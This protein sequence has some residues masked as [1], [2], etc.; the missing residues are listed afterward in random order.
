MNDH[1]IHQNRIRQVF[2]IML[3]AL[4]GLLL[5]LELYVFLPALLGAITLYIIMREW[6][7]HLTLKKKWRKSLTAAMLMF[8]ALIIILLPIGVLINMLSAKVTFAIQHSNELITALKTIV[9]DIEKKYD[10]EI[11]SDENINT[12]SYTHL[13]AHE[14]GRNIV[15]RLLLEKKKKTNK[16]KTKTTETKKKKTKKKK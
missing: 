6:M 4:L 3:I 7:F 9:G 8:F 2:F 11:V 16:K 15:C 1:L 5:F 12:V 13:R 14:T 10:V